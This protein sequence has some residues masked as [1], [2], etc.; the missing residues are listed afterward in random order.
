MSYARFG[1]GKFAPRSDVYVYLDAGGYLCCCGCKLNEDWE[2]YSTQA[3]LDHLDR[4]R[5]AGDVVPDYC[6]KELKEDREAN[7]AWIVS[8]AKRP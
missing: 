4:H 7:D 2:H 5:R 8:Q 6:S 3:I 1:D